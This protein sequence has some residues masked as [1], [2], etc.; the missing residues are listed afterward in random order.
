MWRP[1]GGVVDLWAKVTLTSQVVCEH[2]DPVGVA[3][4]AVE[5]AA[6]ARG[7]AGLLAIII[8]LDEADVAVGVQRLVPREGAVFWIVLHHNQRL[9]NAGNWGHRTTTNGLI[10]IYIERE[11][12]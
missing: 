11:I 3:T 9:G 7:V 10:C 6:V 12:D 8:P 2:Q 1:T 5:L 4:L